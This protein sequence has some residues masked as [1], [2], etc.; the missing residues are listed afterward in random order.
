MLSVNIE[1][2]DEEKENPSLH[3][4]KL[5]RYNNQLLEVIYQHRKEVEEK[6]GVKYTQKASK[7]I[8]MYDLDEKK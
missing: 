5:E 6:D 2:T 7:I 1:L 4:K 3:F 8:K